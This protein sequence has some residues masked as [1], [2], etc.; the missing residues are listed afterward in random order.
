MRVIAPPWSLL[1]P[2]KRICREERAGVSRMDGQQ[3]GDK[4]FT[5]RTVVEPAASASNRSQSGAS[6]RRPFAFGPELSRLPTTW[7]ALRDGL[8]SNELNK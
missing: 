5:A 8:A 4:R 6:A 7:R 2:R 3:E 1:R